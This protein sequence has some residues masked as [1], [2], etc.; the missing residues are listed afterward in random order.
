MDEQIL[1]S[2]DIVA[3][4]VTK[5]VPFGVLVEYAGVP[6]LVRGTNGV[7]GT[8]LNLRVIE[9]DSAQHRFSAELA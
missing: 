9:F 2:G 3:A 1:K 5:P 6:G 4:T 8:V 7:S